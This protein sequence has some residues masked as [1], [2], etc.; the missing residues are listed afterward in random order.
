MGGAVVGG[1]VTVV[2]PSEVLVAIR[3]V[4]ASGWVVCT[5]MVTGA[6][7]PEIA[8]ATPSAVGRSLG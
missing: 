4:G 1:T 3:V 7:A 5:G 2:R 8:H 6:G